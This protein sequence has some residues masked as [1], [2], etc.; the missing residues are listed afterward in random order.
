MISRKGF[1][2]ALGAVLGAPWLGWATKL[3]YRGEPTLKVIEPVNIPTMQIENNYSPTSSTI[4]VE[5]TYSDGSA[6]WYVL[7]EGTLVSGTYTTGSA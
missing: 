6:A 1:L 5:Y 4:S 7:P 2:R 3:D